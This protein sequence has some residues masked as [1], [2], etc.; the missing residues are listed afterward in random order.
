MTKEETIKRI[1]SLKKEKNAVILAHYYV[2]DELQAIADFTGDSFYLSQK[3]AECSADVIVFCGVKFMGESAKIL[4]PEKT[5]YLPYPTA[6]C[7]MAH[8]ASVE[9]IEK[10][11]QEVEDLAVVCYVNSTAELKARADVCVTSSNALKIVKSL[12]EKNIYFIPDENL[13]SFVAKQCPD[14]NFYFS[15]GYCH[16]HA[17]L[18]AEDV[19]A[20]K[21][22]HPDCEVLVHPECKKDVV[23]LADFAGSTK[24]II[25]YAVKSEKSAFIIGTERGVLY[26]LKTR[27]PNKEFYPLTASLVCPD[28][29]KLDLNGVLDA[30][31]GKI[32]PVELSADTIKRAAGS[33]RRMLELG[34]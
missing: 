23:A 32:L 27:C 15:G 10:I 29:K 17:N 22:A 2:A 12:K 14:K 21:A 1:L 9:E 7:P 13:G 11:R 31:G 5:V 18:R 34:K 8:L 16:V 20:A 30:L 28:M 3:A 33:L 19:I 25:E 26:E 6:D 24:G 4:S